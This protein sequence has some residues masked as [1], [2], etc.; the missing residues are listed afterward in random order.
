MRKRLAFVLSIYLAAVAC[1]GGTA[2][3]ATIGVDYSHDEFNSFFV[4]YLPSKVTVAQ[5]DELVFRQVWT[6]EPHTVTGGSLADDLMEKVEPYIEKSERGEEIPDEPPPDIAKLEDRVVW[7]F[8]EEGDDYNQTGAQPCYL[9][10]GRPRKDGK[11]CE[12]QQQPEFDGKHT[13]YNSGII[14]Y[15]GAQGNEYRVKLADDIKPG[16]YWFYCIVHGEFQST[17]VTVKPRGSKVE[18]PAQINRA[19]R[20]EI[21]KVAKPFLELFR[22]AEEDQKVTVKD[23]DSGDDLTFSGNFAGLM[24]PSSD[25]WAGINEFVPRQM[26]ARAG[27]KITWIMMGGHTIS[28]GVPE[29]FP[30]IEFKPN[31][32]VVRNPKLDPPAGGAR[33]WKEPQHEEGEE[34]S[35][36]QPPF[37]GGTYDGTGFWSSG[38]IF[39]EGLEYSIRITKPGTYRYACLVHPPMVG[40]VVVT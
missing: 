4:K 25:V 6:G 3:G 29:Y 30:V 40:T 13:F 18:S 11:P 2:E 1:V 8:S 38:L 17:K 39:G 28:F 15:E 35:G 7:A 5:G 14:P 23:P 19:A 36:P 24:D 9:A 34:G 27:Q 21:D 16:A 32:T 22:D 31:G 37:D 20:A 33:K 10:K 26:R 12:T